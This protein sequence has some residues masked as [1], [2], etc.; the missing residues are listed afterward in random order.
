MPTQYVGQATLAHRLREVREEVFGEEGVPRLAE[1]L[2]LPAIIWRGYEAGSNIPARVL[3]RFDEISGSCLLWLLT[4]QGGG[5][6]ERDRP[7]VPAL[8]IVA[9]GPRDRA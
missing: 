6:R 9:P 5:F 8:S 7:G 1:V 3:L 2:H 4:G